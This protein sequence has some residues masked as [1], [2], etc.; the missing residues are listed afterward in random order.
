MISSGWMIWLV[1]EQRVHLQTVVPADLEMR[2]VVLQKEYQSHAPLL[3]SL[4][5][6]FISKCAC[7]DN[8]EWV[9]FRSLLQISARC[10]IFMGSFVWYIL[11]TLYCLSLRIHLCFCIISYLFLVADTLRTG[12][13]NALEIFHDNRFGYI[14]D[15]SFDLLDAHVA[16]RQ[17]GFAEAISFQQSVS[18]SNDFFWLDDLACTGTESSLADCSSSGFGNENCGASEGVSVT[19]SSSV[20][21]KHTYNFPFYIKCL[22][23]LNITPWNYHLCRNCASFQLLID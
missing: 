11:H 3:V 19:C 15:D 17:L 21:G 13:N 16:C 1:L 22:I 2:T 5:H 10:E 6:F 9:I 23:S 12:I 14:C 20:F 18:V 4:S 7:F 8:Y